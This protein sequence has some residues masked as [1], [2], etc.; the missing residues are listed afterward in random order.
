V[1]LLT[2]RHTSPT[3]SSLA[4]PSSPQVSPGSQ[5]CEG[6]DRQPEAPVGEEHEARG[7]QHLEQGAQPTRPNHLGQAGL[8]GQRGADQLLCSEF[9]SGLP[10]DMGGTARLATGKALVSPGSMAGKRFKSY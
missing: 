3:E 2:Q 7:A 4:A 8:G 1:A 9:S 6:Q 10:L 5:G